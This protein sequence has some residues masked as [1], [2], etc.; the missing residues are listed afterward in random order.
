[1]RANRQ[2][3]CC[4][5]KTGEAQGFGTGVRPVKDAAGSLVP[6]DRHQL[7]L[8]TLSSASSSPA[9][10]AGGRKKDVRSLFAG[11][12]TRWR[13]SAVPGVLGFGQ[14]NIAFGKWSCWMAGQSRSA[15]LPV[16]RCWRPGL[17][18]WQVFRRR[19]HIILLRYRFHLVRHV[20]VRNNPSFVKNLQY[21]VQ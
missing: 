19:R 20:F 11:K 10:L 6:G 16:L 8:R 9:P 3:R 1:M 17:C 2:K 12:R 15:H 13:E 14:G 7:S 21:E 18:G 4:W 5:R